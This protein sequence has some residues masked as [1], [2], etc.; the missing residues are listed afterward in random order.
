MSDIQ[1]VISGFY[2]ETP[3]RSIV[4]DGYTTRDTNDTNDT[5]LEI[6][7]W[8][9]KQ[10]KGDLVLKDENGNLRYDRIID[11]ALDDIGSKD[12][13]R[14][15]RLK[16]YRDDQGGR[17][18]STIRGYRSRPDLMRPKPLGGLPSSHPVKRVLR[19]WARS[20]N[21]GHF[22]GEDPPDDANPIDMTRLKAAYRLARSIASQEG[23][24]F[25]PR[26]GDPVAV[27]D[28]ER[29]DTDEIRTEDRPVDDTHGAVLLTKPS[30]QKY[31]Y[32][33]DFDMKE[34]E[35]HEGSDLPPH[36]WGL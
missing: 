20:Q 14:R 12:I 31:E 24:G 2:R 27:E 22:G 23:F 30:G 11:L 8:K 4:K 36:G 28:N 6:I 3:Y 32:R 25:V 21:L 19:R 15:T 7:V 5:D 34:L 35:R 10:H 26:D 29:I 18:A 33:V 17:A 9:V 1:T 16:S 13:A